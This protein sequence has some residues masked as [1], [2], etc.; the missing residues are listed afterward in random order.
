MY[1]QKRFAQGSELRKIICK[2]QEEKKKLNKAKEY[3]HVEVD[4]VPENVEV[5]GSCRGILKRGA[6][7]RLALGLSTFTFTNINHN[8][9][10][11]LH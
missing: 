1:N 5:D 11:A 10:L 2:K 4:T 6:T 9:T 8:T 7:A 3:L